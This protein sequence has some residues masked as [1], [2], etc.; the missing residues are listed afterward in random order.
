MKINFPPWEEL[1]N[2]PFIPLFDNTD[3]YLILYGGRGSSKSD[4]VA[5]KLIIRCL[6]E[7]YFRYLLVRKTYASVKNSQWQT[8]HDIIVDMG[9]EALFRFNQNP[10][11][12]RCINGN[13]FIAAGCDDPAK[14][15]STKDPSGAWYEEDVITESDWITISTSIRTTKAAYLQ[16]VFTINPEI[17]GNYEDNWFWQKFFKDKAEKNFSDK[18]TYDVDGQKVNINFTVHHS[19]WRMNKWIP[20]DFIAF[21]EGLKHTNPYYYTIY[22]LGEWGNKITGGRAYKAFDRGKHVVKTGYRNNLPVHITFDFNVRPYMTL[23]VWQV[24][25]RKAV[26]V[27]EIIGVE[28]NNSTP[29]VCRLFAQKYREHT[30]GVF[31]YG[32]PA[33]KQQDTRDER[34][35]NDFNIIYKELKDFQP[36]M[37]I[38]DVAP[39]VISRINWI[40]SILEAK[41]G[42]VE[43][44]VNEKCNHTIMDYVY[45]KEAAD[46]TKLKE[47]YKDPDT[48]AQA[49]RYHHITDANDYF[50]CMVFRNEFN[51]Y[52]RGNRE[53]QYQVGEPRSNFN[54]E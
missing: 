29:K 48:G 6:I 32:D 42:G 54:K 14:L 47:K 35:Y 50:L 46:G 27:D 44:E 9:L 1:V 39:P 37:R 41:E 45:G 8:I 43:I 4:F 19:T 36:R 10:L 26:Q 12:I 49:E 23:T 21:L 33:G 31:V 22:T 2:P 38:A 15:K 40:N 5:K 25:G 30:A 34:G 24:V 11:E 20:M 51:L 52:L 7:P 16:E 3:R 13:K 28:P 53:R 18:F 17:E